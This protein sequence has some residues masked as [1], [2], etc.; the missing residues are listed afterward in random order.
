[1]I[2]LPCYFLLQSVRMMSY[3]GLLENIEIHCVDK[4]IRE[5]FTDLV[6]GLKGTTGRGHVVKKAI[7]NNKKATLTYLHS[8]IL[9][10]TFYILIVSFFLVLFCSSFSN[11]IYCSCKKNLFHKIMSL[12][13]ACVR[14][15]HP[16]CLLRSFTH[17]TS[18]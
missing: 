15:L 17:I 6:G 4:E 10:F 16:N 14:S 13:F 9:T 1:M 2:Q 12:T 11:C 3:H 8:T 5:L 18:L 7:T